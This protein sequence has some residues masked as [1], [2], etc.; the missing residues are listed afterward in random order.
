MGAIKGN[1]IVYL[2]RLLADAKTMA[3]MALAFQTEN[4][5]TKSRD[6]DTV[7]TK[8]GPIR[9]PGDIETEISATALFADENDEMIAKLEQAIDT[10]NVWRSG[11]LILQRRAPA[12]MHQ[13]TKENISRAM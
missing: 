4:G 5:R 8:D 7:V 10:G 2:Y 9:V 3:A 6:S 11:K 12:K 1:K 13:N